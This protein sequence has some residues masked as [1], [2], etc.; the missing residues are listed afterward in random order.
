MSVSKKE[1]KEKFAGEWTKHYKLDF[2]KEKGFTRKQCKKC[3]VNFWTS[4]EKREVCADSSCVGYEFIGKKTKSFDYVETWREIEKYFAKHGHTSIKRY[5]TVSR[6]RDDLYFTNAS[7]IDFQPYVVN[8]EVEPPANPLIVP[9]TSIRFGDVNNVGVTGRHYTCFVM[10]GQH[11]FNTKKTGMFYWKED[12]IRDNYNYV[13]NVLGVKEKDLVFQEEVWAG[14]GSFGP[15]IEYCANG[16]ELGNIVFMQYKDMGNGK[17][18][19]LETKVID[20]GAGLE[21]LAWFTNG[22]ATSYEITFGKAIQDMKKFTG[23]K[24]DEKM[25]SDYAKLAG[26]LS[27]DLKDY[28]KQK[29][30]IAKK[31][32]AGKEFFSELEKLQALYAIADH[33]KNILY[34]TNDGMLPSN[35]GGGYNLR[36]L[37]RRVFAFNKEFDFNLDYGKIIENHAFHL[38]NLDEEISDGVRT[39]AE[40]TEEEEKKYNANKINAEKKLSAVIEKA[41]TE[42]KSI[43]STEL[44]KLYE[45]DGIAPETVKEIAL[46]KGIEINVPQNFYQMIAKED[47]IEKEKGREFLADFEKTLPLYYEDRYMQEF[48]AKVLGSIENYLVLDKTAFYPEGGGQAGDTGEINGVKVLDTQQQHGVVLHEMEKINSFRKG[49]TVIGKIDWK[50]RYSIMKHHT[51]AH[52]LNAAAREVL[53]N[54]IWQGGSKKEEHKA[55]LDLTHFKKISH[56]ELKKIELN[57]NRI[58]Q[59]NIEIE[60][61][62]MDRNL[63]EQKFGFRLYQ[64]GAVP[65][66]KLRIL[67]IKGYDVEACGGTHLKNTGEIGLFK[68]IKREGTK[69]GIERITY[70]VG[71]SAVRFIQEKEDAIKETAEVLSS[72]ETKIAESAKRIIEDWKKLRKQLNKGPETEIK[73]KN[74]SGRNFVSADEMPEKAV[75][76]LADRLAKENPKAE[77]VLVNG[78]EVIVIEGNQSKASA[79]KTLQEIFS[80]AKGKGGGTEKIAKGKI[81]DRKELEKMIK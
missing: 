15:C 27:S 39:A 41:K 73:V 53:G 56:E 50:K 64:G 66:K 52:I 32:G 2:F 8:G 18:R 74:P 26:V 30:L 43:D 79:K 71:L 25:F 69:D 20:M 17:Y 59:E 65:G 46:K 62:E 55:H 81:E 42:K 34:T 11:A 23:I 5:P 48:Q 44:M 33:L 49:I 13:L 40:I 57:A 14:G 37:L 63:A 45:S 10:F 78:K 19:D 54:H 29:E 68:I 58:I 12:A 80:K 4:D 60:N 3:G 22:T 72:P 31:I 36:M 1:L 47:E 75:I 9:Q 28:E 67:N 38:R 70:T 6:W 24:M 51:S 61:I 35:S 7:I 77:F 16:I 76:A 21:R